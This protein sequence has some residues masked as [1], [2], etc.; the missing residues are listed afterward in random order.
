MIKVW[1]HGP[2][3]CQGMFVRTIYIP[4]VN[5]PGLFDSEGTIYNE[6]LV[7]EEIVKYDSDTHYF[8]L[9]FEHGIHTTYS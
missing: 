7:D 6:F 4:H 9:I 5:G 2:S 3:F 8:E 1:D